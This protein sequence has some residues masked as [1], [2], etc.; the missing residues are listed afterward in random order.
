MLSKGKGQRVINGYLQYY[1]TIDESLDVFLEALMNFFHLFTIDILNLGDL[2]RSKN[3]QSI[4]LTVKTNY[5]NYPN[6]IILTT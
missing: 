3:C 4:G 2:Q 1:R 6:T 5:P